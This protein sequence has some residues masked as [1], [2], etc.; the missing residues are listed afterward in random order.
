MF[1][2]CSTAIDRS[3]MGPPSPSFLEKLRTPYPVVHEVAMRCLPSVEEAFGL[4]R[5]CRTAF[6]AA[7]AIAEVR[8]FMTKG[9]R[10]DVSA[11]TP[12]LELCLLMRVFVCSFLFCS[13][14]T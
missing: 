14:L 1:L 8:G 11:Q 6:E 2:L 9:G 12:L 7:E 3:L 13:S 4:K 5:E 10:P